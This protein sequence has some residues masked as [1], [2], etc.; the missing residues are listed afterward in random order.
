MPAHL[1][2]HSNPLRFSRLL[3]W[4]QGCGTGTGKVARSPPLPHCDYG[5]SFSHFLQQPIPLFLRS[6]HYQSGYVSIIKGIES[7]FLI[8]Y[9]AEDVLILQS[10]YIDTAWEYNSVI[11]TLNTSRHCPIILQL[12]SV[13]VEKSDAILFPNSF[14][15]TS[16]FL[17]RKPVEPSIV[18][19]VEF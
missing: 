7:K 4:A 13:A 12:P 19:S 3:H 10:K 8:L 11:F 17:P 18:F 5:S 15:E 2:L 1:E 14:H 16:Y 6:T 9:M